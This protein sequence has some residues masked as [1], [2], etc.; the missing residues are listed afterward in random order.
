MRTVF[1]GLTVG[2]AAMA[3]TP[4]EAI[5]F[6]DIIVFGDSLSDTGNA[7][8]GASVLALPDPAP[9]AD[10]Y[11]LGRF[12]NGPIYVDYLREALVPQGGISL[13]AAARLFGLP[14][15]SGENFAVG[16]ARAATNGDA[17]TDAT[18]QFALYSGDRATRG[19]PAFDADAL[20][21][22]A[23]GSNDAR[24]IAQQALGL[25]E[26]ADA[27][28]PAAAGNSVNAL[29]QA[30]LVGGAKH[31]LLL[32]TPDLGLEPVFN[33]SEAAATAATEAVNNALGFGAGVPSFTSCDS[34]YGCFSFLNLF[35]WSRLVAADP[36][37]AGLPGSINF[38]LP[39]FTAAAG[40]DPGARPN[41]TLY[42]WS[43]ALHPASG[44][45]GALANAILALVGQ[46][47][48]VPTPAS[49]A[50]FGLGL[51]LIG[52]RGRLDRGVA[53]RTDRG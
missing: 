5:S 1:M 41:C 34:V 47:R 51:V 13:P 29:V 42:G 11:F 48:A 35:D 43:D 4:A 18:G 39:C 10:G 6:S 20:Y 16:G 40:V 14:Q 23:F 3:A 50:L 53:G 21:I 49:L 33:G 28:T 45:H 30:L 2:F 44:V 17:S 31:V 24:A 27:P 32:N 15:A 8:I 9:A 19:L 36:A 25:P 26:G 38:E 52:A 12:S 7:Q 22:V 37:S 46:Q